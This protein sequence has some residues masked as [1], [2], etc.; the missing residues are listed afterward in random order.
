MSAAQRLAKWS[1]A[2]VPDQAGRTFVITGANSGLGAATARALAARGADVVLACRNLAKGAAAAAT[3][4]G[5]VSVRRLDLAELASVAEFA[6]GTRPFDVLVNNAGVMAVPLRRTVDG[7]ES[8]L[9]TNFLGHF[10][11]TLRLLP[12]ISDRVVTVASNAH[13]WGRINID[14]LNWQRR[15]YSRWLAYGQ[16]KL[17]DLMFAYELQRRLQAAGSALR[18]VAAHP[19]YAATELQSGTESWADRVMSLGNR[20]V[21][22]SADRGALP[23]LYAA[24]MPDVHGGEYWGPAGHGELRGHPTRVGSS[25][26]SRDGRTAV[27]LWERAEELTGVTFG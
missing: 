8:Q 5:N 22:Q 20:L 14:D 23:I 25:R 16:S 15:R 11:L 10:A 13:R 24:T 19:G 27:R 26:S 21:A 6:A 4:P 7:F 9:G 12:L 17:A 3:M 1:V 2:D 18:S